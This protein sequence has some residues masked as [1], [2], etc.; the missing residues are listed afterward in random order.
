MKATT[1]LKDSDGTT[2]TNGDYKAY[3]AVIGKENTRQVSVVK[4]FTLRDKPIYAGDYLGTWKDLGPP[5]PATFPMS[6]TIADDYTGKMF[7]ANSDFKPFGS[8]TQDAL[9][10]MELDGVIIS[11]FVLD[12]LIPGYKGGCLATETLTGKFDE[13]LVAQGKALHSLLHRNPTGNAEFANKVKCARSR[14]LLKPA[15]N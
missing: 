6:L 9:I 10:T 5:G 7:Y 2:I 3:I 8:G 15:P 1:A 4:E 14:K 12:Q 13:T 11:S